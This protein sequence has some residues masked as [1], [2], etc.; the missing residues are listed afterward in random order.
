VTARKLTPTTY[1]IGTKRI[2]IDDGF[3]ETFNR[4]NVDL[5]DLREEPIVEVTE[6]GIRTSE[7]E[8]LL[9]MIVY[10]TGFDAFTGSLLALNIE[11]REGMKL[12]DKWRAAGPTTYLGLAVAGFPNLFTITGPGSPSL[13]GNVVVSIEQ[14]V[15]WICDF[16]K[17]LA[18]EG[19]TTVE[20]LQE[21]EDAWTDHVA[22]VASRTLM[23]K[24]ESYYMGANVEGKVRMFL[25]Y[26]GGFGRY[27]QICNEIAADDHRGFRVPG[28]PLPVEIRFGSIVRQ[29]VPE[30]RASQA[31]PAS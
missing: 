29:V 17:Q 1:L 22:R 24:T 23:V 7:R 12:A 10:A 2:P 19:A 28:H 14:H 13:L 9:D 31:A 26:I 21:A 16:I 6:N 20:A 5:V 30:V 27:R 25:P 4:E 18:D 3:Y 8:I 11:G 15:E